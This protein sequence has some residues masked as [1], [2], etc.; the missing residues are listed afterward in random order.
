MIG[1]RLIITATQWVGYENAESIKYKIDFIKESR[2]AGAMVWAID[3]DDFQ[4]LCGERNP[5]MNTIYQGLKGYVVQEKNFHTT[6][7]VRILGP[8]NINPAV[9]F[10]FL[11]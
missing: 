4:G 9:V 7:T 8:P 2:Y 1:H 11:T 10:V 5:L 3:M 6:P